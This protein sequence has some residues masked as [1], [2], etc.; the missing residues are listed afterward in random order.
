MPGARVLNTDALANKNTLNPMVLDEVRAGHSAPDKVFKLVANLPYNVATPI[1]SNLLVHPLL[2]PALM[3]VTIQRELADR[4][5]AP[6]SSSAYGSLSILIQSL[7]DVAIVRILQ[8]S[9]FWPRPKVESAVVSIRPDPIRRAAL[10]VPWFHEIVR[11]IF[12]HR[13]KNL[14]HVLSDLWPDQWTKSEV[15]SWLASLGFDGQARAETLSTDQFRSLS[16][17]LKVRCGCV[18]GSDSRFSEFG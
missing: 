9:V 16:H 11:K 15:D 7:A 4:M 8:P 17:E 10:D 12:L 1:V 14:R 13:R 6:P 5:I 18:P 3:V 2:C